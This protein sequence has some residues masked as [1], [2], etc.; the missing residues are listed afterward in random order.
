MIAND[1]IYALIP[2]VGYYVEH[3]R[4]RVKLM[5]YNQ[6]YDYEVHHGPRHRICAHIHQSK[7]IRRQ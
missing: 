5:H 1:E 6:V 3:V 7:H 2:N 4:M